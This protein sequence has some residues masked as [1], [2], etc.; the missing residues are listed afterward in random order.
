MIHKIPKQVVE[1]LQ[2]L[3][4]EKFEAFIVG[5]C[6]RDLIMDRTPKDW[7]VTTNAK[8]DEVLKLFPDSFYE[9]DFGT[10]GVK[11]IPFLKNGKEGRE[12]DVVE[13]TTYRIESKYS[14]RRRPDEVKFAETLEE[15]LSRRDFGMNAIALR[16]TNFTKLRTTN[17]YF[18]L[19][20]SRQVF[21]RTS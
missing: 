19:P 10:V 5:G 18:R 15:D 13:V 2:K 3:Q 11:T 17:S 21:V 4:S 16:I 9:N 8:P 12:H 7:D 14:D 1:V 6:V 20:A